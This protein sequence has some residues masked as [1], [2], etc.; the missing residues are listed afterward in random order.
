[1]NECPFT[2]KLWNWVYLVFKVSDRD[3]SS[4]LNTIENWISPNPL[5]NR[6]WNLIPG[7]ICWALWK[8]RNAKIFKGIHNQEEV[9]LSIVKQTIRETL[10]SS[11]LQSPSD[12]PSC[13]ELCILTLL[14]LHLTQYSKASRI[15]GNWGTTDDWSPLET[16]TLKLNYDGALKGNPGRAS[17][18]GDFQNSDGEITWIYVGNLGNTTN[19]AIKL[20]A[21]GHRMNS[22]TLGLDAGNSGKPKIVARHGSC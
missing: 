1:M 12:P 17:L 5:L 3:I 8:E 11:T 10:A 13:S 22:T 6:A 16:S 15:S 14:D 19:N 21:L 2:N 20:Q 7:I 18:G 4:I 9:V